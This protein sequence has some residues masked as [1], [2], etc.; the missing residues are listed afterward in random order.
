MV[1]KMADKL[2]TEFKNLIDGIAVAPPEMMPTFASE[3]D[4]RKTNPNLW[5]PGQSGNPAGR[6]QGAKQN[7]TV[8]QIAEELNFNPIE[9]AILIIREDPR[10]RKKFK[11]RQ[12]V[13]VKDKAAL[14]RWVGDKMY[15]SL[16]SVDYTVFDGGEENKPKT[17]QL[18]LP[19][20]GSVDKLE[21]TERE[22]VRLELTPELGNE[23]V[24][25]CDPVKDKK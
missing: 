19:E 4:K 20:K 18:Y 8:R 11:I 14:L 2:E 16:K 24:P 23:F 10:I 12:P 5:K 17:I 7:K 6:P 1:V 21:K 25:S 3:G 9:A 22:V 13:E 15:A